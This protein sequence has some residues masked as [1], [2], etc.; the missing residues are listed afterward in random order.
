MP[1]T[2]GSIIVKIGAETDDLVKGV[3]RAEGSLA[4]LGSTAKNIGTLVA[5]GLVAAGSAMAALTLKGIRLGD[6]MDDA[7]QKIGATVTELAG[8][9]YAAQFAGVEAGALDVSLAKLART[10][11]LAAT[12]K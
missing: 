9:R 8:M 3:N 6:E 11:S 7:A 10:T 4:K 1:S 5:A 2:V 12:G